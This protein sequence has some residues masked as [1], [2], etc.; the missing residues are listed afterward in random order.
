MLFTDTD[1]LAYK[2]KS[3]DVYEELFKCKHLFDF[4]N[5]PKDS[6]FLDGT[7]KKVVRTVK[8]QS[9]GKIIDEF[10]GL[11]SKMYSMKN[12]DG[13][14][15]NIAKGLNIATEFNEFK[16]TLFNKK[17]LRHKM[18]RIES[19]KHKMGTYQINKISFLCFDDK[20]FV[21]NDRTHT[22][23]YSHKSSQMIINKKRFKK[24]LI[25]RRDSHR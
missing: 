4:S 18:R 1:S 15:S 2:I 22:L 23:A 21:L 8:D 10:V 19:K 24:I 6:K 17:V 5:Y 11:K 7:N 14:E 3:E 9:E 20:R 25:K 16:E 12:V 13:K